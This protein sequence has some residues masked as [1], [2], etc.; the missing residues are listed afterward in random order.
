ELELAP[1]VVGL[2]VMV[3]RQHGPSAVRVGAA[4][5]TARASVLHDLDVVGVVGVVH[6]ETATGWIVR[7]ESDAEQPLLHAAGVDLARDVQERA[8]AAPTADENDD[9][10]GALDDEQAMRV[11]RRGGETDR[12]SEHADPVQTDAGSSGRAGHGSGTRLS[13][14]PA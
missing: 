11:A 6:V 5:S 2:A 10:A 14:G 4:G 1:V 9:P 13:R 12:L 8:S 7:R 3:D